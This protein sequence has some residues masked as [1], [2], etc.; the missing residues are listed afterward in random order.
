MSYTFCYAHVP[1][2]T[3]TKQH[4]CQSFGC[5][6]KSSGFGIGAIRSINVHIVLK[7]GF[8]LTTVAILL[9]LVGQ[10]VSTSSFC[11]I[12]WLLK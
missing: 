5:A 8:Y 11:I 9:W 2:S 4:G 1:Q 10:K 3:V 12:S 7:Y 6:L